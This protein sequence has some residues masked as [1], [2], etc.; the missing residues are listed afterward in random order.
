MIEEDGSKASKRPT[1]LPGTSDVKV[2][3]KKKVGRGE[4]G[5]HGNITKPLLSSSHLYKGSKTMY[6]SLP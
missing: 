3:S 6:K 1:S 4:E 2:K 5:R